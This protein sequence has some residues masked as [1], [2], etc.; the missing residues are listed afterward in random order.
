[1]KI[2]CILCCLILFFLRS[3]MEAGWEAGWGWGVR[4]WERM[5][6]KEGSNIRG[7]L[8]SPRATLSYLVSFDLQKHMVGP[9]SYLVN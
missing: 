9:G 7:M 5:G 1:M 8:A 2:E 4:K 3:W 6:N